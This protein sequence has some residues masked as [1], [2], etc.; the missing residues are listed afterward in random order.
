MLND[1]FK[2]TVSVKCKSQTQVFWLAQR[3]TVRVKYESQI[4]VF[5][6]KFC[7]FSILTHGWKFS[8][9]K[10]HFNRYIWWK[11]LSF[12]ENRMSNVRKV[13]DNKEHSGEICGAFWEHFPV[14]SPIKCLGRCKSSHRRG[15]LF[16]ACVWLQTTTTAS[17]N[18]QKQVSCIIRVWMEDTE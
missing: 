13:R 5:C 10:N 6:L 3:H 14:P 2:D 8:K 1:L 9:L 15:E 16:P 7:G 12:K 11:A 17:S 4:Q 18:A